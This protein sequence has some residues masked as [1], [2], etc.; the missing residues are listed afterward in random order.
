[1]DVYRY[2][3]LM[4]SHEHHDVLNYRA[5]AYFFQQLI[6]TNKKGTDHTLALCAGNPPVNSY[7]WFAAQ[8][9][10]DTESVIMPWRHYAYADFIMLEY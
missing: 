9:A 4:P 7:R 6:H 3:T 1:M 8:T 10:S 5:L 2:D